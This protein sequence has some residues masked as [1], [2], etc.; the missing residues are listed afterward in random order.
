MAIAGVIYVTGE[1]TGVTTG[2]RQ[3]ALSWTI[4]DGKEEV[5]VDLAAGDNSFTV[6]T[7]TSLVVVV[8]PTTNVIPLKLKGAAGDTGVIISSTR[9]TVVAYD[10]G[11]FIVNANGGA[12]T[13]ATI[14]FI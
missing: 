9:P 4:T 6:P 3:L 5:R 13:G 7:G 10:S 2:S 1:L 11:P 8:P 12:V 14:Y